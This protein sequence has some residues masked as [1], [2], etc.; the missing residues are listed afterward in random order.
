[1]IKILNIASKVA[2]TGTATYLV[3][4]SVTFT[5][6]TGAD[7]AYYLRYLKWSWTGGGEL[8]AFI[9]GVAFVSALVAMGITT[10]V[11]YQTVKRARPTK[12]PTAT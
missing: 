7:F 5:I 6:V 1:M 12:T 3:I 10:W 4:W 11:C 2:L 9:H 8:P